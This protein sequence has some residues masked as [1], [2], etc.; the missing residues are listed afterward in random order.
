MIKTEFVENAYDHA[1]DLVAVA[2][3]MG[4]RLDEHVQRLFVVTRV[5]LWGTPIRQNAR[6]ASPD[7][8]DS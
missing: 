5:E 2:A 7:A 4:D 3:D 6:P 1:P 8:L